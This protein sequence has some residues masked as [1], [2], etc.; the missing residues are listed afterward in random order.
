MAG[1]VSPV[2]PPSYLPEPELK[3]PGAAPIGY[4]PCP[5][6]CSLT[7]QPLQLPWG[8]FRAFPSPQPPPC[9]WVGLQLLQDSQR[10]QLSLFLRRHT[11][12]EEADGRKAFLHIQP[13]LQKLCLLLQ[14]SNRPSTHHGT[15]ARLRTASPEP[16]HI[17]PSWS[18]H[19]YSLCD[20]VSVFISH[21]S[22]S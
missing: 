17:W 5:P 1:Q 8:I 14:L 20:P 9:S 2:S 6:L 4:K 18:V 21:S 12:P 3:T 19:A 15:E 10:V 11:R 22:P 7:E 13:R 16:V